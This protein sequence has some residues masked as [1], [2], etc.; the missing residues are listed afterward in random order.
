MKKKGRWTSSLA[1]GRAVVAGTPSHFEFGRE[2]KMGSGCTDWLGHGFSSPSD[3]VDIGFLYTESRTE[4]WQ[5]LWD[6]FSGCV[7]LC[8]RVCL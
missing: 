2:V 1:I 8:S 6:L 7:S 4:I 5:V 3:S